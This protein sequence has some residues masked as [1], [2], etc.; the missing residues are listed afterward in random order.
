MMR[1]WIVA[2]V[3]LSGVLAKKFAGAFA[4]I[5]MPRIPAV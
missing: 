4:P 2:A 1:K 5:T 3:L